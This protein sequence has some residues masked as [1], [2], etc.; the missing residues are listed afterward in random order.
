M[1]RASEALAAGASMTRRAID[2][3]NTFLRA[4]AYTKVIR[5]NGVDGLSGQ[6]RWERT[7][8][9]QGRAVR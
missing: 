8:L 9:V 7:S 6:H 3:L 5:R 2:A 1:D 4:P